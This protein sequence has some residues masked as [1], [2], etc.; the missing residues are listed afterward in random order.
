MTGLALASSACSS[1]APSTTSVAVSGS[2]TAGPTCPV[3]RAGQPCPPASVHGTVVAAVSGGR[4]AANARIG[5]D[6]HYAFALSPGI[7]T[8]AV[9]TGSMLPRCPSRLVTVRP[10]TPARVDITCDTGIR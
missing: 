9:D 7:Y 5:A 4:Q 6:G 8:F 10:G 2:V 1:G 3:E